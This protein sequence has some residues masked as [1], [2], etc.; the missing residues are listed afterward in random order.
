MLGHVCLHLHI[1]AT[2]L[3]I[4]DNRGSHGSDGFCLINFI[5]DLTQWQ[6]VPSMI[7]KKSDDV[8]IEGG[9]SDTCNGHLQWT[10]LA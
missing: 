1:A 2:L 8:Q 10:R 9:H 7:L 4:V 6:Q 5:R 3:I